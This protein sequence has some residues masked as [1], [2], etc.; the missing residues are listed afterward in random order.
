MLTQGQG[1][2]TGPGLLKVFSCCHTKADSSR[3][4]DLL[5]NSL[6]GAVQTS[7]CPFT[8][9]TMARGHS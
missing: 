9:A 8:H 5:S 1:Y 3:L 4:T 7:P 2:P 6:R